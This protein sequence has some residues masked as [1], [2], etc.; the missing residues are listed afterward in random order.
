MYQTL[1]LLLSIATGVINVCSAG[2]KRS[3]T[4][5]PHHCTSYTAHR[6]RLSPCDRGDEERSDGR[7]GYPPL[8]AP[9]YSVLDKTK[10]EETFG[11]DIPYWADS[12]RQCIA[13]LIRT[14]K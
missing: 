1:L 4:T 11:L 12:L 7:G 3:D 14:E 6:Y 8:T 9:P 13:N 2:I 5:L 10:I